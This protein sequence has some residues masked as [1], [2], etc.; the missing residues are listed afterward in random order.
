MDLVEITISL[1]LQVSL[2]ITKIVSFFFQIVFFS[3]YQYDTKVEVDF[4]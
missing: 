2:S 4:G 1:D 3:P